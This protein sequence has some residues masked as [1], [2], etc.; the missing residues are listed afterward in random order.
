MTYG[1]GSQIRKAS[2][3]S[4]REEKSRPQVPLSNLELTEG[5]QF[6]LLKRA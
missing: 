5:H 3:N 4:P 2:K 1:I 6:F